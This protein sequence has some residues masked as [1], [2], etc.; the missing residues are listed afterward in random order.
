MKKRL[1]YFSFNK[2]AYLYDSLE[3]AMLPMP[4]DAVLDPDLKIAG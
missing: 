2:I 3:G 1:K 4:D